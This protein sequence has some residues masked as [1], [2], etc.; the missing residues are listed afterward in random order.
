MARLSMA[1]AVVLLLLTVCGD[2]ARPAVRFNNEESSDDVQLCIP[3]RIESNCH[4]M[5]GR[6]LSDCVQEQIG[7]CQR[8]AEI[9][10]RLAQR[11]VTARR[12][13]IYNQ[14]IKASG[15]EVSSA[16]D[17]DRTVQALTQTGQELYGYL[18]DDGLFDPQTGTSLDD[19][20]RFAHFKKFL[21]ATVGRGIEMFALVVSPHQVRTDR[22]G[23]NWQAAARELAA[24]SLQYP[25]LIGFTID[26]FRANT[27]TAM[28]DSGLMPADVTAIRD[29]ARAINPKF[30]FWPTVYPQEYPLLVE[31]AV[32]MGADYGVPLPAGDY[33]GMRLGFRATVKPAC[34]QLSFR[35][36]DSYER[37]LQPIFENRVFVT[38]EVNGQTLLESDIYGLQYVR[39]FQ[40]RIAQWL[41]PGDNDIKIRIKARS[42]ANGN[43][44]MLQKFLHVWDLALWI[45]HQRLEC[46]VGSASCSVTMEVGESPRKFSFGAQQ[47]S[48]QGRLVARTNAPFLLTNAADGFLS[49][50]IPETTFYEA[51]S[52]EGLI[53]H[54][55]TALRDKDLFMVHYTPLGIGLEYPIDPAIVREEILADSHAADGILVWSFPLAM[56]FL[57][58]QLGIFS[59]RKALP[60][61]DL[62]GFW[63]RFQTGLPGWFQRWTSTADQTGT[64][65]IVARDLRTDDSYDFFRKYVRS[66]LD[67]TVY[68]DDRLGGA[69]CKAG[70]WIGGPTPARCPGDTSGA[71]MLTCSGPDEVLTINLGG[72]RDRL[73]VGMDEAKGVG[74]L[75][76]VALFRLPNPAA[77]RFRSG[78]DDDVLQRH[79]D[80]VVDGYARI[81]RERSH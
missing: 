62:M 35:Y 54:M 14:A 60:G 75:S 70:T 21:Q 71:C 59:E 25:H 74:D 29:A 22:W 36:T 19:G 23:F 1:T 9:P 80:A 42:D 27:A 13:G 78:Y 6:E 18:A 47:V 31:P 33:A 68:Y 61:Y 11:P 79:F 72:R 73:V 41:R 8:R 40:E 10:S 24:L 66:A 57:D 64:L 2:L 7:W 26:D 15:P 12:L 34:A 30:R 28:G 77:W 63:P 4:C 43:V 44:F 39:R 20:F 81:R 52:Y 65:T 50:F 38:V 17:V 69:E 56:R 48:N 45:N 67:N 55:K 37:S 51:D 49:P 16:E 76:E 32:T 53:R 46:S 5:G 58:E 3:A